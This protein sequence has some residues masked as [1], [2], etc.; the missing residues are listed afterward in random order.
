MRT[1]KDLEEYYRLDLE[2]AVKQIKEEKAE[3][4]L[5]QFPD[6]LKQYA[7][8]IIDYLEENTESEFVIYLGTCFGAC[9]TPQGFDKHFDLMIQFGHNSLQPSYLS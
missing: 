6:G 8:A 1:I 3:R 2:K 9:D 4:V 5:V 7:L